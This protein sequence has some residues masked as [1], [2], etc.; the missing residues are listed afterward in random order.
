MSWANSYVK[1]LA[2]RRFEKDDFLE[3]GFSLLGKKI[4]KGISSITDSEI[5]PQIIKQ[6]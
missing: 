3:A 5:T 2:K 1:E 6:K 4:K